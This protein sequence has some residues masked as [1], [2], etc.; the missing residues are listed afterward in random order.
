MTDLLARRDD[1]SDLFSRLVDFT[2]PAR[3][4]GDVPV[5]AIGDSIV[6]SQY[7]TAAYMASSP[8]APPESSPA[9][10]IA[11]TVPAWKVV[12]DLYHVLLGKTVD[13]E[14]ERA[15][16]LARMLSQTGD[17]AG[18]LRLL[19]DSSEFRSGYLNNPT[20]RKVTSP[21]APAGDVPLIYLLH[22]P[23]TGGTTLASML[24]AHFSGEAAFVHRTLPEFRRL[25][26]HA[27]RSLRLVSGHFG[28]EPLHYPHDRPVITTTV[29]RDPVSRTFSMWKYLRQSTAVPGEHTRA[30]KACDFDQ[31]VHRGERWYAN[32]Q[33]RILATDFRRSVDPWPGSEVHA[34]G[35]GG[36]TDV[37]AGDCPSLRARALE[38]VE[39][40]DVLGTV[41]RLIRVYREVTR[42]AGLEPAYDAAPT[43][44]CSPYEGGHEI[45][46]AAAR[47]IRAVSAIDSEL[48]E[49]A[50]SRTP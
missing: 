7:L 35:G 27:I 2:A 34:E 46:A 39:R 22:I 30:A 26:I 41:D 5:D 40:I 28:W 17:V 20:F 36:T 21:R 43:M 8:V 48:Y 6:L 4:G 29:L 19:V 13:G 33:G 10:A 49:I 18:V 45:S 3:S 50:R 24:A 1:A 47:H 31:W 32:I 14:D 15:T 12:A 42:R 37:W 44:N 11:G 16:S 38:R 25:S 23:R 9:D